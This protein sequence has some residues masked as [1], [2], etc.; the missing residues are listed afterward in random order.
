MA[1]LRVKLTKSPIGYP[2][3]QKDALKALGLTKMHRERELPDNPAVRGNL[4]KVAHLVTIVE[5]KS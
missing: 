2:K 1:T 3:D 4:R 5:A